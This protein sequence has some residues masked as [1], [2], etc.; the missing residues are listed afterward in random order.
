MVAPAVVFS[1]IAR[2][3]PR[4]FALHLSEDDRVA[5]LLETRVL[6]CAC[7]ESSEAEGGAIVGAPWAVS[8]PLRQTLRPCLVPAR[9]SNQGIDMHRYRW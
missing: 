4:T 2:A 8:A 7:A 1:S 6:V 9:N 3:S 5:V